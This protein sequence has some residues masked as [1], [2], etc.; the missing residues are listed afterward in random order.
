MVYGVGKTASANRWLVRF[1]YDGSGY[2][3][4]ARQPGLRTVEGTILAGLARSNARRTR[5]LGS[6]HLDVASRTDRGVSARANALALRS[7]LSGESLLRC[8][9]GCA[10]EIFFTAATP[11]PE[12]FRTR[13]AAR[14]TYRY[15]DPGPHDRLARWCAAA[16][17]FRG[18]VD[19]RS[20]GRG[21]PRDAPRLV[22]VQSVSVEEVPGGRL[23]EVR[24]R[25]FV[26]G[27]VRKI[28]S[29]LRAH[30]TGRLPLSDLEAGIR[31]TSVLSLPL[32]EPQGLV[33][34]E[35]EYPIDWTVRWQGPNR[36]QRAYLERTATDRWLGERV[37]SAWT[38]GG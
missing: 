10:P 34:W 23:V 2:F 33:L 7:T 20:F 14:R 13:A 12:A 9:N 8:L 5:P 28:V 27:M 15:W 1:G 26:W 19:A 24:A 25:S 6:D 22:E 29:A 17:V 35:V 21:V 37:A 36:R 3:G 32:A 38:E 31:G 16:A 11:V 30:A 18:P 4:W